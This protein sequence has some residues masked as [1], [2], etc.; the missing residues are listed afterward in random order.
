VAVHHGDLC[1][2][3]YFAAPLL[4]WI[5]PRPTSLAQDGAEKDLTSGA[6]ARFLDVFGPRTVLAIAG[7]LIFS[8]AEQALWQFAYTLPVEAGI[9]EYEAAW[10]LGVTHTMGLIGGAV[11]AWLGTRFGRIGPLVV[12]SLAAAMGQW[13]YVGAANSVTLAIGGIFWGWGYYFV[14]PYQMGIAAAIDR[15]ARVAVAFS[16]AA[17]FGFA[18][19]PALGGRILQNLDKEALGVAIVGMTLIS[20]LAMLPLALQVRRKTP[21]SRIAAAEVSDG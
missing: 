7:I 16:A 21:A 3:R 19:G 2:H 18:F 1:R 15:R 9:D 5:P 11:A 20:M 17:A 14:S 4:W 12:G 8:V 6:P 13:I 10:I